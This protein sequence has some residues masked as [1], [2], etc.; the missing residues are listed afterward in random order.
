MSN[1]IVDKRREER[2]AGID[3][4]RN[5]QIGTLLDQQRAR[6]RERGES[7]RER[8]RESVMLLC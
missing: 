2:I 8:E 4:H 3:P 1:L 5:E 7:L 6:G